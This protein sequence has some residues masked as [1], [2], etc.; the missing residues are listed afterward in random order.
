MA[1]V[2]QI[3]AGKNIKPSLHRIK[4]LEY[5]LSHQTHP[6]VDEIYSDLVNDVPTLSK[7][8]IYNTLKLLVQAGIVRRVTIEDHETRYDAIVENHG[9][10][11]CVECSRVYDFKIDVEQLVTPD[12]DQF[13]V[14]EKSV[15]YKGTCPGCL[16]NK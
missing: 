12:L 3:L 9:H 6:T 5:L 7:T 11:K 14:S 10:F 2:L 15:Y 16:A 13:K 8:T 1:M 4:V